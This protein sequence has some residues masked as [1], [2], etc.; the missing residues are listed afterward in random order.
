MLRGESLDVRLAHIEARQAKDIAT[1]GDHRGEHRYNESRPAS[2]LS[3][4]S[5]G[6]GLTPTSI[7]ESRKACLPTLGRFKLDASSSGDDDITVAEHIAW[8]PK[9]SKLPCILQA[10]TPAAQ[11]SPWLSYTENFLVALWFSFAKAGLTH[12]MHY[13]LVCSRARP[14][15]G[16]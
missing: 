8:N 6:A 3:Q 5:S 7:V 9:A 14:R 10:S 13:S 4:D 1:G 16:K 2:M 11:D 12:I 15:P